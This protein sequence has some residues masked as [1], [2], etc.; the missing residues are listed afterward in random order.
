MITVVLFGSLLLLCS[1]PKPAASASPGDSVDG[2]GAIPR[3]PRRHYLAKNHSRNRF[4]L[5]R[6]YEW[7]GD[8]AQQYA[9]NRLASLEVHQHYLR[10]LGLVKEAE[11]ME[12][13][14]KEISAAVGHHDDDVEMLKSSVA[15]FER[16]VA[17]K[18]NLRKQECDTWHAIHE[19]YGQRMQQ[20]PPPPHDE[21]KEDDRLM[22]FHNS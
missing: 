11:Q 4:H 10:T 18:K 22:S 21:H 6:V 16:D 17:V 3:P 12:V 13:L 7:I 15:A 2:L 20:A 9:S 8:D 5:A 19:E 1:S 14:Q